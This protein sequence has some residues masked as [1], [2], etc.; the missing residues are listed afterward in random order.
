MHTS[1]S[2]HDSLAWS[3]SKFAELMREFGL[4]AGLWLAG[5]DDFRSSE[6][7]VCPYS[8]NA[9]REDKSKDDSNFFQSRCRIIV[10]CAFGILVEN[11]G[12]LCRP[13]SSTLA[14]KIMVASVCMKQ[15]N[16]GVDNSVI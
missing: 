4:P 13:I 3:S 1:G 9:C 11:W 10:E 7:L 2:T 6:Y 16:L 8:L 14:P 5:D 15:H 12:I